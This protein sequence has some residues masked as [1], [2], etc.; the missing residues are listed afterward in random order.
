MIEIFIL[1]MAIGIGATRDP[2]SENQD[3]YKALAKASYIQTGA[4]KRIKEL[5]VKYVPKPLK[6]YGSWI[7]GTTKIVMDKKVSF[8]WTF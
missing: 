5:E 1:S 7:T 6:K 8:E 4:N 3:A 2:A